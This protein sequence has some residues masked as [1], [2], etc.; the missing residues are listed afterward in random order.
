VANAVDQFV[1]TGNGVIRRQRKIV[2]DIALPVG[3]VAK[4]QARS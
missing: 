3:A 2:G 4:P 1:V